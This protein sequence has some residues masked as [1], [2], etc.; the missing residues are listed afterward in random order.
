MCDVWAAT[1]PISVACAGSKMPVQGE[2]ECG[3]YLEARVEVNR[4]AE[5][6]VE[7]VPT[8]ESMMV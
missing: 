1:F 2:S 5:E 7:N 6:V 3:H 4:E 8:Y